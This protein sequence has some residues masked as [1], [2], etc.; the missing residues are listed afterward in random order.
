MTTEVP[1]SFVQLRSRVT[2]GGELELSLVEV[3]NREPGPDEV[4]IRVEAAP[5]NPSDL[6]LLLGSADL[7][8][9]K[10][11]G[12]ARQPVLTRS[13]EHTSELQSP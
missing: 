8:T 9:A 12:T 13:E 2:S 6:G 4:L 3:A 7:S 1:A 10:L 11:S 5:I